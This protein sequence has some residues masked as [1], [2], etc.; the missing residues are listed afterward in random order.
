MIGNSEHEFVSAVLNG[1]PVDALPSPPHSRMFTDPQVAKVYQAVLRVHEANTEVTPATVR[2]ELPPPLWPLLVDLLAPETASNPAAAPDLARLIVAA[3]TRAEVGRVGIKLQ[4][5][6]ESDRD[7]DELLDAAR[8]T[9][10]WVESDERAAGADVG[11]VLPAV[12]DL[13][14]SGT[15]RGLSTGMY[16][17]DDWIGGFRPGELVVVGAGTGVGKSIM[18]N[19]FITELAVKQSRPVWVASMEMTREE[20]TKRMLS[21]LGT[22]NAGRMMKNLLTDDDW[23]SIARVSPD[24]SNAPVHIVDSGLQT[25][26]GMRAAV[27]RYQRR[28]RNPIAAVVVDYLQ[29]VTG[30]DRK[31]SREREVAETAAGLKALAKEFRTT[32]V[33]PAQINRNNIHR[34]DKQPTIGDMRESAAIEQYADV[35]IL[36]HRPDMF[37]PEDCPGEVEVIIAKNRHGP[38]G[39]FP[40]VMQ[41]HYMRMLSMSDK[42]WTPHTAVES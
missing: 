11:D 19:C 13:L 25:L 33:A 23:K 16:D 40:M 9:L 35:V 1:F 22:V 20:L 3:H 42:P 4:Q 27:R 18:A 6:A 12:L 31:A 29:Q 15:A 38:L 34:A 41:P 39:Q 36:L 28:M 24:V 10:D 30:P 5:L 7:P 17:L 26:P 37:D 8:S 14:E 21:T 32:V 2:A